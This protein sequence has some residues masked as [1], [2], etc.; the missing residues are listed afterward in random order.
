[1]FLAFQL[2]SWVLQFNVA[3]FSV[4][5]LRRQIVRKSRVVLC[6]MDRG[7]IINYTAWV[8]AD[9]EKFMRWWRS[10]SVC[11]PGHALVKGNSNGPWEDTRSLLFR[12]IY[13][14]GLNAD[15][16]SRA[17]INCRQYTY[18]LYARPTASSRHFP[19]RAVN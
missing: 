8:L 6:V 4:R 10:V 9:R 11:S 12:L 16:I 1:M 2:F 19:R 5:I 17:A 13:C 3:K 18:V 15:T 14:R 7:W